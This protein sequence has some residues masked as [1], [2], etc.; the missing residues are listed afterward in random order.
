MSAE[1]NYQK[2]TLANGVRVLT[3]HMPLLHTCPPTQ[4]AP[5]TQ[6]AV[7]PQ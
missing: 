6:P 5:P 1:P 4:A 2:T 3:E 7:A